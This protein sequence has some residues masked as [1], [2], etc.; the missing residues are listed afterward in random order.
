M[1]HIDKEKLIKA[2]KEFNYVSTKSGP[3]EPSRTKIIKAMTQQTLSPVSKP[4]DGEDWDK[5]EYKLNKDLSYGK[6]LITTKDLY[7]KVFTEAVTNTA[8]RGMRMNLSSIDMKETHCKFI[9]VRRDHEVM[10]ELYYPNEN[11]NITV[12]LLTDNSLSNL[13]E[14]PLDSPQFLKNFGYTILKTCD[15]LIDSNNTYDVGDD[16]DTMQTLGGFGNDLTDL[17]DTLLQPSAMLRES[18]DSD[19]GKLLNLCNAVALMEAKEV[20]DEVSDE[21]IENTPDEGDEQA[22]GAEA[23]SMGSN[24]SILEPT[25]MNSGDVNGTDAGTGEDATINFRE[26]LLDGDMQTINADGDSVNGNSSALD[27]LS[28]VV[29]ARMADMQ[30]DTRNGN[31]GVELSSDEI[32]HGTVG[33]DKQSPRDIINA[34][35]E[36]FKELDDMVTQKQIDQFMEFLTNP[37]TES[38]TLDAFDRELK[39]IFPD[40]YDESSND[41]GMDDVSLMGED[42]FGAG[43]E[44]NIDLGE[45]VDVGGITSGDS[46]MDDGSFSAMMDTVNPPEGDDGSMDLGM[47]FGGSEEFGANT[48][49]SQQAVD[50]QD[51]AIGALTNI[52]G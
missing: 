31:T 15:D 33:L 25:P 2:L 10:V 24:D 17:N 48:D 21:V 18:V 51:E 13:Y 6:N 5:R 27:N 28:K 29:A 7:K 12:K 9:I 40:K 43:A 14:V 37:G 49:N 34:F 4:Q 22:P 41:M 30:K 1:S 16:L 44:D 20:S 42:R 3:I 19:L 50:K 38:I 39:K 32:Y 8:Y 52:G 35:F 11:E 23:F 45:Q 26:A 47:D 36:Y 46:F